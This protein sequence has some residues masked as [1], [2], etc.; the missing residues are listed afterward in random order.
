ME[1]STRGNNVLG[2][3]NLNCPRQGTQRWM[4]IF[5]LVRSREKKAFVMLGTLKD[6]S[7]I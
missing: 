5:A 4:V 2:L 6:N 7:N 1:N 3:S